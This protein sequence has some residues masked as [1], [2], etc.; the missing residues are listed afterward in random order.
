M[1]KRRLTHR[2]PNMRRGIKANWSKTSVSAKARVV[3][4]EQ[5]AIGRSNARSGNVQFCNRQQTRGCDVVALKVEDI[6]PN[7]YA[8]F[9]FCRCSDLTNWPFTAG[10]VAFNDSPGRPA[11]GHCQFGGSNCA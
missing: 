11:D 6:A 9:L 3:D 5:T 2:S 7:G 1:I 8:R 4:P 10:P